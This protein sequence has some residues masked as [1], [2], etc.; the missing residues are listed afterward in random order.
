MCW[1]AD[2]SAPPGVLSFHDV[3]MGPSRSASST[4]T[5][6]PNKRRTHTCI[7]H[8]TVRVLLHESP[9]ARRYCVCLLT[10]SPHRLFHVVLS[11]LRH[12]SYSCTNFTILCWLSLRITCYLISCHN[13]VT[14]RSTW[15]LP[16]DMILLGRLKQTTI[17]QRRISLIQST[18]LGF[19]CCHITRH[20]NFSHRLSYT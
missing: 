3:G 5:G 14:S 12:L 20:I 16:A 6:S 8:S 2:N 18:Y 1:R 19:L 17:A 11:Q 13:R 7:S 15:N 4:G 9:S 10:A